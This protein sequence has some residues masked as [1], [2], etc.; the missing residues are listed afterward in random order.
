VYTLDMTQTSSYNPAFVTANGGTAARAEAALFQAI[1]D[2]KAYL[3]LHTSM[4]AAGEIRG[5]LVP[6]N[7]TPTDATTWGK[8]KALYR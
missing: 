2:G 3:N 5:F 1:A 4:F 8:V 6:V 7:P